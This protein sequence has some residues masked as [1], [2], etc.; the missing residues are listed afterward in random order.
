[1]EVINN[2]LDKKAPREVISRAK[3]RRRGKKKI[4]CN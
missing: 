4:G 3:L 1:V 2:M